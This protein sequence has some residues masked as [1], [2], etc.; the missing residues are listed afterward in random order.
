VKRPVWAMHAISPQT[1]MLA[2][3]QTHSSAR[4]SV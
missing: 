4:A 1:K 3:R 2:M